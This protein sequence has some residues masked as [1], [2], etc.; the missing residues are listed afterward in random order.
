MKSAIQFSRKRYNNKKRHIRN[1]GN[2]Q[3]RNKLSNKC[4]TCL[5]KLSFSLL[6]LF[7]F[8]SFLRFYNLFNI[9]LF[10]L[11]CLLRM[12]NTFKKQQ[13]LLRIQQPTAHFFAYWNRMRGNQHTL[14]HKYVIYLF[15]MQNVK[16]FGRKFF[17]VQN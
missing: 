10:A 9:S 12:Q 8:L 17:R 1:K 5:L 7:W 13:P 4:E 11:P 6:Y 15:K 2:Q 3:I 16:I 14:S